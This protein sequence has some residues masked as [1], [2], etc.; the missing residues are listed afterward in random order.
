MRELP[1]TEGILFVVMVRQHTC[2]LIYSKTKELVLAYIS[3]DCA[4]C[5]FSHLGFISDSLCKGF[6]FWDL[7][8]YFWIK[9]LK[10]I[11]P[12]IACLCI[13]LGI[14][15]CVMLLNVSLVQVGNILK[16]KWVHLHHGFA[17]Q[18]LIALYSTRMGKGFF[19]LF[20]IKKKRRKEEDLCSWTC[21][22]VASTKYRVY[23]QVLTWSCA[24][25]VCL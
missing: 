4:L 6:V 17:N 11:V 18:K 10:A 19:F 3:P 5:Y 2:S 7:C 24:S 15:F 1:G 20:L 16:Y 9:F 21:S 13:C 23:K 14:P 8:S 12:Q 22:L 25:V